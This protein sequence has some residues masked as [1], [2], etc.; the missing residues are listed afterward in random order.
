M[1]YFDSDVLIHYLIL[2]DPIK[3][4]TAMQTI[5]AAAANNEVAI[6][7][8]SLQEVA[9]VL[10]KLGV[11]TKDIKTAI[12]SLQLFHILQVTHN[13]FV[14][15]IGIAQFIGFQNINDCIHTALAEAHCLSLVSFNHSDFK[16]IQKHSNL[17]IILL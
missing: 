5:K 14:R 2:Q 11:N 8:L 10:G 3:Q 7:V 13:D 17:P 1:I 15:A 6:S 4:K 9:Y 16:R 12:S